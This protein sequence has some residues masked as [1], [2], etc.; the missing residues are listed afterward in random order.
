MVRK[1]VPAYIG[2]HHYHEP[3]PDQN[4]DRQPPVAFRLRKHQ[5]RLAGNR[6][7]RIAAETLDQRIGIELHGMRIGP[8]KAYCVSHARKPRQIIGFKCGQK[9][10]P[11]PQPFRHIFKPPAQFLAALTQHHSDTWLVGRLRKRAI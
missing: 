10:R 5:I 8:Q 11:D 3:C 2:C 9:L 6:T 1:A 4:T 7:A